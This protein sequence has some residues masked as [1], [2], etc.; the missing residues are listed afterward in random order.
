MVNDSTA[1]SINFEMKNKSPQYPRKSTILFLR[2]F[3]RVYIDCGNVAS[4][5]SI[6]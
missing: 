3:A 6:N 1:Y 5:Y 4:A 2:Q